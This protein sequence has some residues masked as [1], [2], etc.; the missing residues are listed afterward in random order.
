LFL[1]ASRARGIYPGEYSL[2]SGFLV[3]RR[4]VYLARKIKPRHV[5]GFEGRAQIARIE[6]VILDGV[7]R[8]GDARVF[9]TDD[10]AHE[11]LLRFGR[12]TRRDAVRVHQLRIQSLGLYK[13]LV[14]RLI[15]ETHDLVFHRR[16]VTRPDSVYLARVHW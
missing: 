6:V 8:L 12:Q 9:E 16:T 5:P 10:R 3:A 13:N 14:R 2:R 1:P 7:S 11:T 15:G 4:T